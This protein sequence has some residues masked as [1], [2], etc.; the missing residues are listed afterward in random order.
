MRVLI[1]ED[2]YDMNKILGIYLKN[3]GYNIESVFDGKAALD[4]LLTKS[5]DLV[6]LD[7]M[8]P[9]IDGISICKKI[10]DYKIPIK[11]IILTAKSESDNEFIGLSCGADD[12]IKK[13]F[14]PKVLLLRIKKL[15]Y[16][17]KL[18][19]CADISLNPKTQIVKK[20]DIEIKLSKKEYELLWT[21]L[22]NQGMILSREKLLDQVW[23]I[24]YM[25]D[26]RTVD[27][28]IRRLRSK[29]GQNYIITH[30]GLGYSMEKRND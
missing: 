12:Y 7:W 5:F 15:F 13:P 23:G 24:D 30:I 14:D 27:T 11:I 3:E 10:R 25:G 9:Y 16:T 19:S 20:M 21:L 29:I 17:E 1:V 8:I 6:I 28:H 22:L 4:I 26:E 2:E 18:L